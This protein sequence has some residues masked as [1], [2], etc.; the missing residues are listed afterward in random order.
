MIADPVV[1]VDKTGRG[2]YFYNALLI[3]FT[4]YYRI[5]TMV[6]RSK[7]KFTFLGSLSIM[8]RSLDSCTLFFNF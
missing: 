3:L 4:S 6:E 2:I 1:L 8:I 5:Y 7:H